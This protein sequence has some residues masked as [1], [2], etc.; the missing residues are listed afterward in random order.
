M[1]LEEERISQLMGA[2]MRMD[3]RSVGVARPVPHAASLVAALFAPG[4]AL[5][6]SP[7][8]ARG[9]VTPGGG[10]MAPQTPV[11]P[12]RASVVAPIPSPAGRGTP[13]KIIDS[14]N[15]DHTQQDAQADIK[16]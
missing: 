14:S 5:T 3:H 4:I 7:A 1:A 2:V 6:S 13:S 15:R 11:S 9:A 10:A 8:L 16:K 12:P